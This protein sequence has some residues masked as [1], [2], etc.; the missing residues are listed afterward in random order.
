MKK[1][2]WKKVFMLENINLFVLNCG[3]RELHS[4]LIIFGDVKNEECIE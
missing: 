3:K 4:N 2:K 1:I